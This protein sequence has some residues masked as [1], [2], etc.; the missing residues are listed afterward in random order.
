MASEQ[1]QESFRYI[2]EILVILLWEL[3]KY[4]ESE[5]EQVEHTWYFTSVCSLL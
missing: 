4:E 2:L 3:Y 1:H 5:H